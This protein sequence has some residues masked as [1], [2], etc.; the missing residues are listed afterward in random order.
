MKIDRD[1]KKEMKDRWRDRKR[2]IKTDRQ[3]DGWSLQ[4]RQLSY[5]P[6]GGIGP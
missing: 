3:T 1:Q 6:Q 5:R 2:D 4:D